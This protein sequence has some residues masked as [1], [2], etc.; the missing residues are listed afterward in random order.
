M[1]RFYLFSFIILFFSSHAI[2]AQTEN[3]EESAISF[4]ADLQSR[5]IWRGLNLGGPSPSIQPYLEYGFGNEQHA[6]AVG[7]WGAFSVSGAQI[8][9]EA[10]LYIS[11]T[12]NELVSLTFTDYFFPIDLLAN[13]DYYNFNMDWDKINNGTKAQTRH[14]AEMALSFNGTETIPVS[15]L[16]AMNVWGADSRKYKDQNGIMIPEDKIQMTKYVELGYS[17]SKKNIAYN[18]FMGMV[19]DDPEEDKGEPA[20]FYGQE[21]FGVINLGATFS[22]DVKINENISIPVSTSLITNPERENIFF[23]IGVSF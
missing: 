10:D 23:V 1:K 22:K 9:Q 18:L 15:F 12:F 11:Y 6:F 14:V 17:F 4:G 19:L 3:T 7:A 13:N 21:S 20:G 2:I 5:Y 8:V 16:F